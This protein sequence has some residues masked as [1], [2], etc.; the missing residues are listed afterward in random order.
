M[1]RTR[2]P[3]LCCLH[4]TTP[5]DHEADQYVCVRMFGVYYRVQFV[6][7]PSTFPL[8]LNKMDLPNTAVNL[9]FGLVHS[10]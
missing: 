1:D 10:F 9:S 4:T 5:S 7:Y 2:Y 3:S 6:L 8:R